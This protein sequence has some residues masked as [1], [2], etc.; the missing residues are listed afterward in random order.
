MEPQANRKSRESQSEDD[1]GDLENLVGLDT[2]IL[3]YALDPTFPEHERAK[4]VILSLNRW[5][6]NA[7]VVHETYHTLV[8][9]RKISP[10]DTRRKIVELLKD[11]RTNFMNLTEAA[12]LFALNLAASMNLGGRDSLI[13]GSY[14]HNKIPQM[15]SHDEEL[16]K[17]KKIS[18]RGKTLRITDPIE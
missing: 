7:T 3:A 11:R 18:M 4:T 8:F 1:E 15:Y 6:I 13:I 14:L 16:V 12:C 5:A 17:F 10:R 2:N 9:R